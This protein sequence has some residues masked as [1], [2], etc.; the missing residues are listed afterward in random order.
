V[1]IRSLRSGLFLPPFGV[2]FFI[3]CGLGQANVAT[4]TRAYLP[5]LLMLLV[6]ILIVAFVPWLALVIPHLM[7]F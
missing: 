2:G 7:N 1:I 5:Y 4:A 3:A 6:G